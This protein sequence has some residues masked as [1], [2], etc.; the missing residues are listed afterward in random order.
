MLD[1][2]HG[3]LASWR[4]FLLVALL[5]CTAEL[6]TQSTKLPPPTHFR[7]V[8]GILGKG[9]CGVSAFPRKQP[10]Q[11]NHIMTLPAFQNYSSLKEHGALKD[12]KT[13]VQGGIVLTYWA[14]RM[15]DGAGSQVQRIMG[16]YTLAVALHL[17]YLHTPLHH[18]GYQGLQALEAG[19][20]DDGLFSRWRQATTLPNLDS[21]LGCSVT[22]GDGLEGRP[23]PTD[24]CR[25]IFTVE[26]PL[27]VLTAMVQGLA[28]GERVMIHGVWAHSILDHHAYLH[29][30]PE[31]DF[32]GVLPWLKHG[33][34]TRDCPHLRIA[35]HVRRGELYVVDGHRMLPNTY[36]LQVCRVMG[37]V[38]RELGIPH[39]FEIYTEQPTKKITV[40]P[41]SHGIL[42][43]TV[44]PVEIAPED[45]KLFE[46]E[47]IVP[48]TLYLNT[49][50]LEAFQRM[51]TA[52][53]LVMS[54]SSFSYAAGVVADSQHTLALFPAETWMSPPPGWILVTK[55]IQ[56]PVGHG[57]GKHARDILRRDLKNAVVHTFFPVG[58]CNSTIQSIYGLFYGPTP[59]SEKVD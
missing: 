47:N 26:L 16:W 35:V 59:S 3:V 32:P 45:T 38:L 39:L 20:G 58:D 1:V 44:T 41:T 23:P 42:N 21:G 51:A 7:G 18:I 4:Y 50:P 52:H 46:L 19:H 43:R 2:L 15:T 36:Y 11:E 10:W 29:R 28:P 17:D 13:G 22:A 40:D 48:Q 54:R 53:I 8:T 5:F 37:E 12:K 14:T 49:D 33:T 55:H 31:L 27:E 57:E 9:G 25:H 6:P 30:P 34:C 24:G 56:K